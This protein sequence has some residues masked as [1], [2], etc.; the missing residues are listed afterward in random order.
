MGLYCFLPANLH[1]VIRQDGSHFRPEGGAVV[2][3]LPMG[4]LMNYHIVLNFFRSQHQQTVE[5]QVPFGRAAAPPGLLAA[6]GNFSRIHAH[7]PGVLPDERRELFRRLPCQMLKIRPGQRCGF[8]RTIGLPDHGQPAFNP[9]L[10]FFQ[11][12]HDL[13]LRHVQRR[14]KNHVSIPRD[15]DAC[16]SPPGTNDLNLRN[17][18]SEPPSQPWGIC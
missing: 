7:L 4:K 8:S 14:P 15:L 12:R 1:L 13:L 6:D 10:P 17:I 2:H 11:K 9:A 18:Q 5:I 3:V 16:R